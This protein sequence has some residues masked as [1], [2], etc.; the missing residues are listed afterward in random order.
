M[1]KKNQSDPDK[2]LY[3]Q[4]AWQLLGMY[5]MS[6]TSADKYVAGAVLAE[7]V[8]ALLRE[9]AEAKMLEDAAA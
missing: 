2:D 3:R 4:L 6:N 7:Q 5:V 1:G 8:A 9:K